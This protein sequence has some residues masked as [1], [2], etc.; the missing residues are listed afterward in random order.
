MPLG[1]PAAQGVIKASTGSRTITYSIRSDPR[2]E[3]LSQ[4]F[5]PVDAEHIFQAIE[6][7][8]HYFMTTDERTILKRV[9]QRRKEVNQM[10][11]Q[12][13]IVSPTELRDT[14]AALAMP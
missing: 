13:K 11:G 5:A 9:R 12:M 10:C 2:Y 6:N 14:L 1:E 4:V 8:C 3:Q 7:G